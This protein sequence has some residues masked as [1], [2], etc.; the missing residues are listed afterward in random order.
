MAT[1]DY[2]LDFIKGIAT[3][4]VVFLHNMPNYYICSSLWIGQAVPLFL[5][6][7]ACLAS[8]SFERAK[9]CG[10]TTQKNPPAKCSIV[11]SNHS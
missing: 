4:S 10:C 1:R 5:L 3:I 7:S 2:T 9:Q 11:Y 8:A 6:V